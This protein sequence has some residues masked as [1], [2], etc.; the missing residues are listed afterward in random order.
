MQ[1]LQQTLRPLPDE[2]PQAVHKVEGH[3]DEPDNPHV[4]GQLGGPRSVRFRWSELCAPGGQA[5]IIII[6]IVVVVV[7]VVVA[8]VVVVVVVVLCIISMIVIII[9]L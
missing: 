7:V 2:A 4:V 9:V 8:A 5:T 3:M 6:I 1:G